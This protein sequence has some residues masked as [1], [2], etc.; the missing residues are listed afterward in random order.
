[1]SRQTRTKYFRKHELIEEPV[2]VED[3]LVGL[4]TETKHR[5]VPRAEV[6]PET[7]LNQSSVCKVCNF[8]MRVADGVLQ[9]YHKECRQ[10]RATRRHD[11][12]DEHYVE[13]K[14]LYGDIKLNF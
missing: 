5:I 1:M 4:K 12:P 14:E 11:L 13:M 3:G 8:V 7:P 6:L 2:I 9:K 10:Y